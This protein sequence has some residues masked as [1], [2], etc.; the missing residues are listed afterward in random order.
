MQDT[1]EPCYDT[2][3]L[4]RREGAGFTGRNISLR[5][6]LR[7]IGLQAHVIHRVDPKV[8]FWL[9]CFLKLFNYLVVLDFTAVRN[10]IFSISRRLSVKRRDFTV[11]STAKQGAKMALNRSLE[12]KGVIFHIVYVAEIQFESAWA[13]TNTSSGTTCHA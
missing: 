8:R 2:T 12:F 6:I 10:D 4:S 7:F 3:T 5:H 13:L 11:A 9:F 1:E